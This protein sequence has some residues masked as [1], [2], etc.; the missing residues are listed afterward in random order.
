MSDYSARESLRSVGDLVDPDRDFAARIIK[1]ADLSDPRY[2]YRYGEYVTKSERQMAAYLSSLPEEKIRRMATAYTEGYRQGFIMTGK[3]IHKKKT[4]GL[5]YHIGFE[6]MMRMAAENFAD[7]GLLVTASRAGSDIFRG[8]TI[9]KNGFHGANPNPQFD[10]DHREDLALLI[11]GA[12]VRR[13]LSGQR[14]AYAHYKEKAALFGGPAVVET[15]GQAPFAPT[16][17]ESVCRYSGK[18]RELSVSYMS[19]A[20]ALQ[21]EYIKGEERS[22]TIIAFPMPDVGDDFPAIFDAVLDINT[23]D[24]DRYRKIQQTLIDALDQGSAVLVRGMGENRTDLTVRLHKLTNPVNQTNFENCLADVNIPLGEVFTSPLLAGTNGLLHVRRVFLNGLEYKDFFVRLQDGMV[25]EYGCG[26][27]ADAA[28]GEAYIRE[29]VLFNHESLPLGEF[30][31]GTNTAAY[32]L[33]ARFDLADR[34]PIL[35]AE[36]TGP[37]FALGDTCYSHEEDLETFNPDGKAIIARENEVSAQRKE[38]PGKAYFNCHTDVTIPYEELG[39]LSVLTPA[40][41][42]IPILQEGRFVL[43]GTEILNEELDKLFG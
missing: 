20:A 42:K 23:L 18:G 10:D 11:D 27:F 17:K 31:I 29:N 32:A 25:V 35:I 24:V 36:K 37:H 7:I 4:V 38:D 1:E 15:F 34:L 16:H 8:R 21:E 39:E 30:A 6:R 12:L 26:N 43:P 33:A 3:D 2:L 13:R 41:A 9:E 22:F 5:R 14:S 28:A 40:G 19:K